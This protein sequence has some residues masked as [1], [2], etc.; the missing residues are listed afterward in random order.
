MS[1]LD[2]AEL[3]D[4]LERTKARLEKAEEAATYE[5]GSV[6]VERNLKELRQ[7]VAN[8][9]MQIAILEGKTRSLAKL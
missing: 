2:L 3:K 6:R 9:Q 5:I 8:L 1:Y 7:E 4:K